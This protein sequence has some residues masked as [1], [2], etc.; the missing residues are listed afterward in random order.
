[1]FILSIVENLICMVDLSSDFLYM[2]HKLSLLSKSYMKVGGG[3][4]SLYQFLILTK[5]ITL[6]AHFSS[7][8]YN[9]KFVSIKIDYML[10][11]VKFIEKMVKYLQSIFSKSVN[12]SGKKL[13]SPFL[14]IQQNPARN[15]I[16]VYGSEGIIY[17]SATFFP[18]TFCQGNNCLDKGLSRLHVA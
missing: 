10:T 16:T 3:L 13:F 9:Y 17:G 7:S 12:I 5:K 1:M 15:T 4:F 14:S 11:S 18:V 8:I 6:W 2:V